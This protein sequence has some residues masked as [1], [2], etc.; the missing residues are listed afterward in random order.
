MITET[1]KK[2][3]KNRI[4][5]LIREAIEENYYF[6]KSEPNRKKTDEKN[7]NKNGQLRREI[8]DWVRSEYQL[9]STLAY[10]LW[11]EKDEDTARSLFAKKANGEDADG[12]G[13]NFSDAEI[14]KLAN[15]RTQLNESQLRKIIKENIKKILKE[16]QQ[17]TPVFGL[18][19]VDLTTDEGFD[20]M[21][22][23]SQTYYSEEEAIEAA[24]E[25]ANKYSDWDG[26]INISVMAGEYE[27]PSGDV[28]GEPYDIYTVSNK[29]MEQ[30][31]AAREKRGYVRHKVDGYPNLN[32]SKRKKRMK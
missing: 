27:L 29:D 23:T 2:A 13:Y 8:E 3:L 7:G 4:K 22:Y 25:M 24:K 31:S 15:I 11:P 12:N 5:K 18:N 26:I 30:T 19:A 14:V 32:E 1:E 6:E 28:Y 10:H 9:N 16:G 21:K 20:D 17:R